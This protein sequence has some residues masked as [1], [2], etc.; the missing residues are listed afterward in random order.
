MMKTTKWYRTTVLLTLE[1]VQVVNETDK[2]LTILDGTKQKREPKHSQF[3]N[4][5]K[6]KPEAKAYL[7]KL[8][9]AGVDGT[10]S[11]Q[12]NA[13]HELMRINKL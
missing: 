6:T 3:V 13:E 11:L 2:T 7:L 8:A 1:T 4:Y 12:Q 10:K 5:F 9:Q